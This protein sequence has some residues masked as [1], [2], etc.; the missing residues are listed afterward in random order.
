[1]KYKLSTIGKQHVEKIRLLRNEQL[2]ILRQFKPISSMEQEEYFYGI[3]KDQRQVLFSILEEEKFIGYCGLT[4][5]NY[6]YGTAEVSFIVDK[7]D[8]ECESA[9]L[10]CL[11]ELDLC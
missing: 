2:E 7:S 4:N 1:M 5:I 8:E 6:V 3:H 9:F 10:F 11:Q